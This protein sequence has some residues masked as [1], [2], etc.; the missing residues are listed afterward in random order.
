MWTPTGMI[1]RTE[2]LRAHMAVLKE[3]GCNAC[4]LRVDWKR[5][6]TIL[7]TGRLLWGHSGGEWGRGRSW[8]SPECSET[9][10]EMRR[11]AERA[12]QAA[13]QRAGVRWAAEPGPAASHGP[14]VSTGSS[15]PGSHNPCSAPR[16]LGNPPLVSRLLLLSIHPVEVGMPCPAEPFSVKTHF[17]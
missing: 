16:L 14:C 6:R 10:A 3:A 4:A 11:G 1:W 7:V 5:A 13:P 12:P 15:V 17:S 9:E 2:I 8:R